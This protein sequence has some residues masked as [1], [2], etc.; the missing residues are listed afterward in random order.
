MTKVQVLAADVINIGR[1][2]IS[3]IKAER[4][5]NLDTWLEEAMQKRKPIF[6]HSVFGTKP[7]YESRADAMKACKEPIGYFDLSAYLHITRYA[8]R[9]EED[10]LI[11]LVNMAQSSIDDTIWLGA[12][13]HALLRNYATGYL[14]LAGR[15]AA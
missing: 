3:T 7:L 15:E 10:Q 11:N 5:V 1:L 14:W 13:D 6:L 4:L 9:G 8:K 12:N 2:G